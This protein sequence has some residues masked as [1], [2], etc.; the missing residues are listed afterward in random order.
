MSQQQTR[1]GVSRQRTECPDCGRDVAFVTDLEYKYLAPHK[2]PDTRVMCTG[3]KI[4]LAS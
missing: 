1:R 3:R 4:Q 2:K